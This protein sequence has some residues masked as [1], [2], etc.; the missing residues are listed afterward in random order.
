MIYFLIIK[1]YDT[2]M[3]I[4]NVVKEIKLIFIVIFGI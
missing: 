3:K 2:I 1:F 4:I